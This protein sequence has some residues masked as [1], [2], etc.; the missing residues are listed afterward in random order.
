MWF[1]HSGPKTICCLDFVTWSTSVEISGKRVAKI[2]LIS[3]A[4][5]RAIDSPKKRTD[6]FFLFAFLLFT[7]N[8]SN[9]CVRFLGESTARQSAFWFY[10]TFSNNTNLKILPKITLAPHGNRWKCVFLRFT[11]LGL[12]LNGKKCNSRL[13]I[14]CFLGSI[15]QSRLGHNCSQNATNVNFLY[16]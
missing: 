16:N 12:T 13:S 9:S 6:K 10:L 14:L 1:L 11:R 8:K 4:D 2:Q 3:K 15:Y 7:A 5:W